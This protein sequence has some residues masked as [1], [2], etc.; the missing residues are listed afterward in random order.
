MDGEQF[1][2]LGLLRLNVRKSR[3]RRIGKTT[4]RWKLDWYK[5]VIFAITFF[6]ISCWITLR[7]Q[8]SKDHT[9]TVCILSE[10]EN[11]VSFCLFWTTWDFC[12]QLKTLVLS[13]S[14]C[15]VPVKLPIWLCFRTNR[16]SVATFLPKNQETYCGT[17]F[18]QT[19]KVKSA[20]RL[21]RNST[22]LEVISQSRTRVK[23]NR[24][25]F[26]ELFQVRCRDCE[27]AW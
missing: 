11:E 12:F 26:P 23:L 5:S 22:L 6:D 10:I 13:F 19:V 2:T 25:F 17:N 24:F 18:S 27:F 21:P 9:F 15:V 8:E 14:G 16:S 4:S 7:P 20:S 1:N 3:H